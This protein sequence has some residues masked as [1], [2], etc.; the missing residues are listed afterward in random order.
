[1]M[2]SKQGKA[3]FYVMC[4]SGLCI[5]ANV[6]A[7]DDKTPLEESQSNDDSLVEI[8][9]LLIDRTL[10]R[11]GKDFYFTFA[12]KMNSEYGDLE[13]NLTISEVPTALSGSIIT[14]HHFN[15][16]IYKTALSPGRYQAE[17]RAEEAMYVTRNYIVKWK[18]EKQFQDTFDLERSE[19]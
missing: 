1:M 13:V 7:I 12:M 3:L 14:I 15:R 5:S 9:G 4:I 8:Q 18:A 16:V 10:T 19:L 11:L 17:Q 6:Q 2:K